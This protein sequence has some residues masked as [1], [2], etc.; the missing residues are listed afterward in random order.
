MDKKDTVLEQVINSDVSWLV[1]ENNDVDITWLHCEEDYYHHHIIK[2]ND[3]YFFVCSEN[4]F[5]E[6]VEPISKEEYLRIV[7][8][9]KLRSIKTSRM[10]ENDY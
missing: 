9:D 7:T 2:L 3:E 1:Y 8:K 10:N 5:P 4:G 6:T